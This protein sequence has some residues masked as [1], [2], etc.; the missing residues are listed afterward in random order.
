[1]LYADDLN[2]FLKREGIICWGIVPTQ[3]YNPGQAPEALAQKI[4]S[5]LDILVKK[6]INRQLLLE[7]LMI[8]PACGLGTLDAQKAEGILGLLNQT[9]EF[10]HKNL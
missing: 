4:K 8:S 10:S 1:M 5:G 2:K 9:S 6:G 7:R 3:G